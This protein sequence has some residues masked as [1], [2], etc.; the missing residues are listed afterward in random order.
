M[1]EEVEVAGSE[2]LIEC[3]CGLVLALPT[4]EKPTE[5]RYCHA[6]WLAEREPEPPMN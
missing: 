1:S 6:L 2:P 3:M 4:P 5:C